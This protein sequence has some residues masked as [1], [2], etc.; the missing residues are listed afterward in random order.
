MYWMDGRVAMVVPLKGPKPPAKPCV[1]SACAVAVFS[2]EDAELASA[3]T[4]AMRSIWV[5][6][7]QVLAPRRHEGQ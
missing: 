5:A 3:T 4:W 2:S 7:G 6:P 1:G